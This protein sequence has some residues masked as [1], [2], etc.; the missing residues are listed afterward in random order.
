MQ[1]SQCLRGYSQR[2]VLNV[3]E[4]VV[5]FLLLECLLLVCSCSGAFT[6]FLLVLS[7]STTYIFY[8]YYFARLRERRVCAKNYIINKVKE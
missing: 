7:T 5:Y 2:S 4:R 8:Y 1:F 6:Y 3:R